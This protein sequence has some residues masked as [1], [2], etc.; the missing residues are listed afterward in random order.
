M[1]SAIREPFSRRRRFRW[2]TPAGCGMQWVLLALFLL[3]TEVLSLA[4]IDR[5]KLGARFSEDR[6][7]LTFRVFSSRSTRIELYLY[8]RPFGANEVAHVPLDKDPSSLVWSLSLP[9]SRIRGDFGIMGTIYYGYR[10]WGPNWT[11]D[12]TWTKGSKA[13]FIT[14][15]D[16]EGDRFNPNKLLYDPYARELSHDPVTPQQPDGT[17]T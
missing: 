10:A 3:L 6:S 8:S 2:W 14:D 4:Q 5:L 13:G 9:V 12:P 7:Q 1:K 17:D 11:F 15:V 16:A